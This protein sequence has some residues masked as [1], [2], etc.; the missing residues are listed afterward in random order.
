M[1]VV[2]PKKEVVRIFEN[3][4]KFIVR[5]GLKPIPF[6]LST[7]VDPF[8]PHEEL[9]RF[10]E[11][12]L[13]VALNYEQP[14]IINTK[15]VKV[16]EIEGVKKLVDE[17][18]SRGLAVIQIS[19]STLDDVKAK[20]IEPTAPLPSK[21]LEVIR[22]FG[23]CGYPVVIR[24]SPYIPSV[25]P[26][27]E[28]EVEYVL[29]LFKDYGVKHVVV[30]SLRVEREFVE[31]FIK[32]LEGNNLSF[33]GYSLREV[34]GLK[35]IVRISKELR[36]KYYEVLHKHAVRNGLGFSTCKEGPFRFHT[37][38][39]CCGAY[40]LRNY[41]LRMTLWDVYRTGINPIKYELSD[42]LIKS[43]CRKF[44]RLCG[45]ELSGYPKIISKPMKY[46]EKKLLKILRIPEVV[47]H[48]A[49]DLLEI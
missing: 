6:R 44:S 29:G 33:E 35:P 42:D 18:L 47:K 15:S 48:I 16:V 28:E 24:L 5:Y 22:L 12:V 14:L 25:S 39:D 40:L 19:I 46:H 11:H 8:P 34:G 20:V 45:E 26:S 38:D 23:E 30:E 9:Y 49:P 27:D 32:S 7:L 21:R 1:D 4:C 3:V 2:M 17:L 31:D 36:I 10:S 13:K 37:V 43:I 41:V